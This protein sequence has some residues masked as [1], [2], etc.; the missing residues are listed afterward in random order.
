LGK[1]HGFDVTASKDG[2]ILIQGFLEACRSC[3][4]FTTGDLTSVGTD[5][6]PACRRKASNPCSM[7]FHEG[8]GFIGVHAASDTFHT[9][10]DPQDNSNR[11]VAHRETIRPYLR[12]PGPVSFITHGSTPRL[13]EQPTSLS[14]TRVPR[15]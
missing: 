3:S 4:F 2:R 15:A 8:L 9:Q 11:Y 1:E 10:P 13:Q 6:N 14:M 12:M 5:K 7:L